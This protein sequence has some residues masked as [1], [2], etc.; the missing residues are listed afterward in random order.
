MFHI[1]ISGFLLEPFVIRFLLGSFDFAR[2]QLL[3]VVRRSGDALLG[4]K[5]IQDCKERVRGNLEA[6][7]YS[8]FMKIED[9]I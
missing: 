4:R 8:S 5:G 7:I 3:E 6:Q 2:A 1:F 9:S